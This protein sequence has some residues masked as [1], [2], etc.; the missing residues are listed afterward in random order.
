MS[1]TEAEIP[2]TTM[3]HEDPALLAQLMAEVQ[4]LACTGAFTGGP[5]VAA[6]EA[7]YAAW[8]E[9]PHAVGVSSGTEALCLALRALGIGPGD[10]VVVPANSFIATAE[11]VSLVGARP[12]FA[13]VEEDTQLMSA[14]TLARALTPAVSCVVPVH[15]FGRA[16]EMD[17][18]VRLARER[19]LAVLEDCSQAHG[20]RWRGRRVGT[21]GDA[22]TFSFY[23]A[24]NLGAWGDAGAVVT[25]SAEL[26]ERVRLLRSHGESPRYHH[27]VVGTTGRLDAIQAA[28][29]RVK[30][31]RL[32]ERNDARRR[33]AARLRD[34]LAGIEQLTL[35]APVADGGDHVYHQF[36]VRVPHR[37]EVRE[38]L[39]ERGVATGVHYPIPI[40]R[41]QA[42]ESLREGRTGEWLDEA[43]CASMLAGEILS[44]PM[45]PSLSDAAIERIAA[46]LADSLAQA[47]GRG[48]GAPVAAVLS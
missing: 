16:V 27:R 22:G 36:V 47:C 17:A 43:P 29:L 8:C 14:E 42:Y 26:A 41:S 4:K 28:V 13:D 34:A 37:D 20:A 6:F 2:L 11:A 18:I 5:A 19:G 35:P 39:G 38:L 40:H 24:K 23:P 30:L 45:F 48:A 12:R 25:A 21:I 44:L 46:A 10:E 31:A 15:L 7:D 1:G 33:V 9:C 3:D 32:E